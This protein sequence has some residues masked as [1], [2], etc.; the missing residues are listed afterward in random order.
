MKQQVAGFSLIELLAV[1]AIIGILTAVAVPAYGGY[2]T[3]SR[4]VEAFSA[5]GAAQTTAE[6]YW[7]NNHT[8]VGLDTVDATHPRRLP[9]DSANFTFTLAAG[10][11]DSAYTI[12]ATGRGATAGF[13][14]TIDQGGTRA[15][16]A[17]PAGYGAI[18]ASCWVDRKGGQCVQ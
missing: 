14:Y 3:R 7:N 4:L 12:V 11:T 9:P 16:T 6:E 18:P 2:V 15:T 13:T 17:A 1:V 5:L 8:Y 10:A